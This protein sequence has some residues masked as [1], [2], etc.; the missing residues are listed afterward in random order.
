M[1]LSLKNILKVSV[2]LPP[3]ILLYGEPGIGKTSLAAEFPAT[4]FL[5][6]EDGTPSGIEISSFGKIEQF[7]Q[8]ME[9]ISALYSDEHDFQT[10]VVDSVTELERMVW[11]ET[12]GR[13]D[14]K[15]NKK[16][17]IEDF[18]YGKGYVYAQRIWQEFIDGI[19]ALRRDR[20]MTIVL[21]AH[22]SIERFDDPESSSY[23]RYEIDLHGR[24]V[25]AIERDMD[26]IFLI[27]KAVTVRKE[28]TGFNQERAI[29]EGGSATFIHT[30]GRPAFVAKNRYG[31]PPKVKFDRGKGFE[32]IAAYLPINATQG[33]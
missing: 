33:L 30:E 17:N 32:A 3:R 2:S 15:G 5:Q 24:S 11:A 12:C 19:N 9:A 31:L 10:L 8:V 21:I 16:A 14:D 25:G 22:S 26:A 13:G 18:G 29:A 7:S 1:A 20:N 6:I 4:V 27:K 28:G 23:H